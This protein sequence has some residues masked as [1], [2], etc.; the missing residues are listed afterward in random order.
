MIRSTRLR[1][2]FLLLTTLLGANS[3]AKNY[4]LAPCE[5]KGAE[6]RIGEVLCDVAQDTLVN[7]GHEVSEAGKGTDGTIR[8]KALKLGESYSVTA[9]LSKDNKVVGSQ[10]LKSN[11]DELDQVVP[12]LLRSLLQ[13]GDVKEDAKVGEVTHDESEFRKTRKEAKPEWIMGA[14]TAGVANVNASRP[15]YHFTGGGSVDWTKFRLAA[16]FDFSW[17]AG[18][19][20]GNWIDTM[21]SANFFL[22]DNQSAPYIG[23]NLGIGWVTRSLAPG[24]GDILSYLADYQSVFVMGVNLGWEFFRNF[25]SS[26]AL[27]LNANY[28]FKNVGPRGQPVYFGIRGVVHH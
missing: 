1:S 25:E 15:Y 12:R 24:E 11:A 21:I 28:A 9:T 20:S 4:N 18:E 23:P 6:T 2:T 26:F 3:F 10:K 5:A 22:S 27:E 14:G 17:H 7:L 16:L 13:A 19:R 8:V